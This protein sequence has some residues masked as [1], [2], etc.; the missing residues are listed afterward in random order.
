MTVARVAAPAPSSGGVEDS[1]QLRPE[2]AVFV[3][4]LGSPALAPQEAL[5]LQPE[6]LVPVKVADSAR[7][8]SELRAEL[9]RA[10][11]LDVEALAR[12]ALSRAGAWLTGNGDAGAETGDVDAEDLCAGLA[13]LPRAWAWEPREG[14]GFHVHATAFGTS[15]RVAVE[16]PS[17]TPHAIV[18]SALPAGSPA[19]REALVCFALEANARLR[20]ARIGV[21]TDDDVARLAWDA[22]ASPGVPLERALPAAVEAVVCAHAVTRRALRALSHPDVARTYLDARASRDSALP[23]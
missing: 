18:R 7:G 9:L 4:T 15:A 5:A 16:A 19:T 23:A 13:E 3:A 12:C 11:G 22:V 21:A 8:G 17:G 10:R 2:G 20:L 14:G 6:L 1:V